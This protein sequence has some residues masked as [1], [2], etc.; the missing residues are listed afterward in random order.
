MKNYSVKD[1]FRHLRSAAITLAAAISVLCTTTACI[2]EYNEELPASDSQLLVVE[3]AILSDA[4]CDFYLSETTPLNS[5][6]HYPVVYD[7]ELKIVSSEGEEY[8]VVSKN[9][10]H[11]Y[12]LTPKLKADVKYSLHIVYDGNTYETTPQRPT[13]TIGIESVKGSQATPESNIDVLITTA[14]PDDPKETQYFRWMYDETWEVHPDLY[15]EVMYDPEKDEGVPLDKPYPEQGWLYH[16]GT[17]IIA[18]S[19]AYYQNNK[20]AG[21]KLFSIGRSDRRLYVKHSTNVTQRAVTKAEYE[22]EV[23]RRQISNEMGGLFTP[24]P[25]A[26]PSNVICTSGK[27]R[28]I[29]YVGCSLNVVQHRIFFTPRDFN[30]NIIRSPEVRKSGDEGFPGNASLYKAGWKLYWWDDKRPMG[31]FLE[32]EWT[33]EVHLDVRM[34]GASLERPEYWQ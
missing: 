19:S 8:N 2:E 27:H 15:T 7:A 14:Q 12:I 24:Q 16:K 9:A 1:I 20:I 29:G 22:Y 21:Y 5:S 34:I 17:E 3:G 23:A 30:V 10:G 11:Y 32:S 4:T 6:Y 18:S 13:P 25:S 26:L 31:G 28:V 33:R